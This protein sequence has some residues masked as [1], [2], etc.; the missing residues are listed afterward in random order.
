MIVDIS[1]RASV[2]A[3]LAVSPERHRGYL[4]WL[5]RTQVHL[6]KQIEEAMS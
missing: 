5:W 2:Q 1:D 6:R 3:W 4:R